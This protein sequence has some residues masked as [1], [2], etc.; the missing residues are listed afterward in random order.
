[1]INWLPRALSENTQLRGWLRFGLLFW[2]P[3]HTPGTCDFVIGAMSI[4]KLFQS[5][6]EKVPDVTE[7][8]T[9]SRSEK[10]QEQ[11]KKILHVVSLH[12]RFLI[13]AIASR[14]TGSSLSQLIP[15]QRLP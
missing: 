2:V 7:S 3:N 9:D 10:V 1:M 11:I 4:Q 15:G 14:D 13:V 12:M 8:S 6:E 5:A